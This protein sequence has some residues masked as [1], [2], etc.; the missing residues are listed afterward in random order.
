VRINMD[1]FNRLD[2]I[3]DDFRGAVVTIGNFDGVHRGHQHIFHKVLR[4]ARREKSKAVVI[5][6]EPHPK[7]VLHP[8]RQPFY[9]ITSLEEKIARIAETGIDGLLLIP[10]SLEFSHTSAREFI[11]SILWDRLRIKKI[12]IGHD[13]T[14]G[15]GREGNE[16]LLA[17]AGEKLGFAVEVIGAFKVGDIV[18][19]STLTRNL[20]LA[21]RVKEAA[22]YL[23]RPYNLGGEVIAGHRRGRALGFPT[24]NL[25]PDK[26]LVPARGIYA[27][28][29]LL[30]GKT[31]R[32]VL[33]IG[34]NPTFADN[35]L[36]VEAYIFDFDEDIYG[37]RLDVL[38]IDRIRDEMKFDGPA[39]L[40]EQIRRDVERAREILNQTSG[41][42][43]PS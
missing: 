26:A 40:V 11:H 13:Y 29:L 33:N 31:H 24:A 37:Q 38:F 3:P 8:E 16:T 42:P 1:V 41:D 28:R 4:E 20:I 25:R 39:R 17:T 34:F 27:V 36:S 5:T 23:G 18:I 21:G 22:L 9:L 19:S 10:F 12:F 35:A 7:R 2:E 43:I 14:F 30:A 6:F 15:R 32:G